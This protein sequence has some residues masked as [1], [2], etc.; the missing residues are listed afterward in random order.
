MHTLKIK[1][2]DKVYDKLMWLLSKFSK[3][4]IEIISDDKS[5]IETKSYLEKEYKEILNGKAYFHSVEEFDQTLEDSIGK[6]ETEI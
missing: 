4:E 3:D 2:S 5:F 1:I 6:N